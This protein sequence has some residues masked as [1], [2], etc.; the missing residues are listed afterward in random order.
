MSNKDYRGFHFSEDKISVLNRSIRILYYFILFY[1]TSH[2]LKY[3]LLKI[4]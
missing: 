2:E 4:K 3:I 1:R